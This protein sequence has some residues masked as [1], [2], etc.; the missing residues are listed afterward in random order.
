MRIQLTLIF[1]FLLLFTYSC[2]DSPAS[3]VSNST[4]SADSSVF[5]FVEWSSISKTNENYKYGEE[6]IHLRNFLDEEN[7]IGGKKIFVNDIE[8]DFVITDAYVFTPYLFVSND[9]KIL[10]IKE[11]DEGSVYGF[12]L[13]H[14]KNSKLIS[15]QFLDISP[16]DEI[17]IEDFIEFKIVNNTIN[18]SLKTDS[19][20]DTKTDKI[21]PSS[22]YHPIIENKNN[23]KDHSNNAASIESQDLTLQV[24]EANL[25]IEQNGSKYVLHDVI[26]DAMS[27]STS[28]HKNDNQTFY[29]A[30]EN[31]ASVAKSFEKYTFSYQN[32]QVKLQSK[33]I[34]KFGRDGIVNNVFL[35]ENK[36]I[37]RSY[38]Y[39]K[40]LGI[41]SEVEES[42]TSEP[43][44]KIF[45][46]NSKKIDEKVFS[47]IS[48]E[49]Y[50]I[51]NAT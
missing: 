8:I 1:T 16:V 22:E 17:K 36:L 46:K 2:K 14:L 44:K 39:D 20:Y 37:D 50:F 35:F 42:Y 9:D 25:N 29:L 30:Y 51:K 11:E 40:L 15:K 47:G 3:D 21:E 31:N 6:T 4:I 32:N 12:R 34:L 49:D 18:V 13:Y 10:L 19:Y 43:I 45:Y 48:P 27:V 41:E 23:S 38:N 5:K 33:E 26:V 24:S 7:N 28:F